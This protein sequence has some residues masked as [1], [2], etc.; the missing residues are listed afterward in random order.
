MLERAG[1]ALLSAADGDRA[2][3]LVEDARLAFDLLCIDGVLPCARTATVI[4]RARSV[5]PSMA[6]VICSGYV[7][8]EL[9]RRGIQAG[10]Y[11]CVRKPY[12]AAQLLECVR[13]E[14]GAQ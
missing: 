12:T 14:L 7:D 9:L 2:L 1:F 13:S 8:E 3:Q 5:R 6:I 11:A 4:E 10:E